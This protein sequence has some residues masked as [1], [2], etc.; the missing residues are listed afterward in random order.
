MGLF[1]W[2]RG[3]RRGGGGPPDQQ[4]QQA[5]AV[6]G[7]VGTEV[8]A[9]GTN[10]AVEVRRQRQ[11]QAADATVFEFGSAAESG[12]ALTLAGY[13]PVSDELEPCRWELVP[14]AGEGAPQFRIVF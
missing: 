6:P 11:R 8:A 9:S 10:G 1:S 7:V 2:W 12:A 4:G 14:A 5:S 3:G 13:C